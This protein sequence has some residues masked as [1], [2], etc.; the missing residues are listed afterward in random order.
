MT[1]NILII[2]YISVKT[3]DSCFIPTAKTLNNF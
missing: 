1:G 3:L 2:V